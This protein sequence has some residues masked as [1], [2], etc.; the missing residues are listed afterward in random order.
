MDRKPESWFDPQSR[1][2][3]VVC[4]IDFDQD[5]KQFDNL[6]IVQ[7]A[8]VTGWQTALIPIVSIRNGEGPTLLLLGGTHGDEVEGPVVLLKLARSL[9][10]QDIRGRVII[11]PA[12]NYGAVEAGQRGAPADGRDLNRCFP[13]KPDGSFAEIVAHYVDSELLPRSQVAIDLHAGGRDARFLR[14]LW[15]LECQDREIWQRT[16]A[17]AR[18][19]CAPHVV[20]SPSLGGDMSESAVRCGCAYLSTEAGGAATVDR[21]VVALSAAGIA[22]VMAHLAMI[23][24]D[25]AP[26][27]SGNTRWMRVP[28]GL[29]VLLADERGLFEPAIN[30]GDEVAAGQL[31][32]H[33]HR[34]EQPAQAPAEVVAPIGGLVYGLRWLS[35]VKRGDRLVTFAIDE[36]T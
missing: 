22:R 15:L 13:G 4:G 17:A 8:N 24:P 16:L 26:A 18:A 9:R 29:G 1:F 5:G 11:V 6:R 35:Q 12:L 2:Q 33:I 19:F 31:L 36:G 10:P 23:S 21:E 32:G 28:G 25:S 7:S 20:V 14:S 34:I 3:S 27:P 30:L